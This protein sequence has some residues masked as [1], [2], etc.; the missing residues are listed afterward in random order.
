MKKIKNIIFD[1][2]GVLFPISGK[3]TLDRF[4][5]NGL[6]NV[7]ESYHQ[8]I[9]SELFHLF[10]IGK[11]TPQEYRDGFNKMFGLN[12]DAKTFD[13]C[14]NAMIVSYPE[15]NNPYLEKLKSQD[16]NLYVLSNTN[17]IHVRY[18]EPMSQWREG[19]FTKIYYSNEI[20]SRKPDLECFQWV[21]NDAK[22]SAEETVFIDD[23]PD[24][25][26]GA[27]RA[28]LNTINLLKQEDLYETLDKFL[29]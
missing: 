11:I 26:E 24:N 10:E 5:T 25:I 21:I 6:Q 23:R 7:S 2:G 13:E 12:I 28:G 17:E 15:A 9:E 18:L 8:L 20:H 22:I 16:Y 4:Q 3:E 14:W 1:L 19:L 27:R 29:K